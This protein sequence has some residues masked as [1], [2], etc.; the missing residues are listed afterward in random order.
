MSVDVLMIAPPASARALRRSPVAFRCEATAYGLG[1]SRE[2][3]LATYRGRFPRLAARW[4]RAS[5]LR[6]ASLLDPAPE[7]AYF[8]SAP[9]V[10]TGPET[11]RPEVKLRALASSDRAYEQ[12]LRVLT[13]GRPVTFTVT[14]YDARYC[15]R[16]YPLPARRPAPAPPSIP[17]GCPP[18]RSAALMV[19]RRRGRDNCYRKAGHAVDAKNAIPKSF[20]QP[21]IRTPPEELKVSNRA[22]TKTPLS[23]PV[24]TLTE[25]LRAQGRSRV[26][27]LRAWKLPKVPSKIRR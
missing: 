16:V 23:N 4:L 7:A 22:Q 9:L 5:A 21:K 19:P 12:A 13:A 24:A 1:G 27:M 14:D 15:L 17:S 26:T 11:A 25:D 18:H 8:Q 6:L 10:P 3:L 2:I 20:F